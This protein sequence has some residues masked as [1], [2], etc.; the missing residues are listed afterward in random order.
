MTKNKTVIKLS[1]RGQIGT[2]PVWEWR[3][4][5]QCLTSCAGSVLPFLHVLMDWHCYNGPKEQEC[6]HNLNDDEDDNGQINL[7]PSE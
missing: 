5:L 6:D 2:F 3:M 4:A 7:K 1:T